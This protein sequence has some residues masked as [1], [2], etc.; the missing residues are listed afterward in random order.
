MS[1][2]FNIS[3]QSSLFA[4]SSRKQTN[5]ETLHQGHSSFFMASPSNCGVLKFKMHLING[6]HVLV[7]FA[8]TKVQPTGANT[9]QYPAN[10]W[11][12]RGGFGSALLF[13]VCITPLGNSRG[14]G[15]PVVHACEDNASSL[16]MLGHCLWLHLCSLLRNPLVSHVNDGSVWLVKG[17]CSVAISNNFPISR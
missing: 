12:H 1:T 2:L 7:E 11:L 6:V 4:S 9:E 8:T 14:F 5:L 17:R 3:D 10:R 15:A 16:V 13:I